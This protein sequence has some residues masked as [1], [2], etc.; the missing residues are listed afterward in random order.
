MMNPG[1]APFRQWRQG[2]VSDVRGPNRS[3]GTIPKFPEQRT[4][5]MHTRHDCGLTR[6]LVDGRDSLP[7]A[8][9]ILASLAERKGTGDT[10]CTDRTDFHGSFLVTPR[11]VRHEPDE[12]CY[13]TP[14]EAQRP[15]L[16][17]VVPQSARPGSW[18]EAPARLQDR[19]VPISKIS[20]IRIPLPS[21][22]GAK[23]S[24]ATVRT[25]APV[26]G[27]SAHTLVTE[28]VRNYRAVA[29]LQCD[30][31]QRRHSAPRMAQSFWTQMA[32]INSESE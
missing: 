16:P 6:S 29:K 10:D 20:K 23:V 9:V 30:H 26:S 8:P 15:K 13:G 18:R 1:Y 2:P 31:F 32:R 27:N 25:S 24:T 21:S 22:T 4:L 11:A 14:A 7:H 17:E 3:P 28:V 5:G 19:S 12:L